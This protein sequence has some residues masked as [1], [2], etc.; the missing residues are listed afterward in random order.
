MAKSVSSPPYDIIPPTWTWASLV[1]VRM[2]IGVTFLVVL[3]TV[4]KVV[5][6]GLVSRLIT[7]TPPQ[8]EKGSNG[9]GKQGKLLPWSVEMPTKFVT[10]STLSAACIIFVP[11]AFRAIGIER[12]TYFTEIWELTCSLSFPFLTRWYMHVYVALFELRN[13]YRIRSLRKCL[14]TEMAPCSQFEEIS[15]HQRILKI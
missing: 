11:M 12:E 3:R 5:V 8:E 14:S 1:I 4:L 9:H 7:S 13:L 10:Y 6:H 15:K 2:S